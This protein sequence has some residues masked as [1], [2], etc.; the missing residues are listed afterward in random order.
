[1]H[2]LLIYSFVASS[3]LTY[4]FTSSFLST[5]NVVKDINGLKVLPVNEIDVSTMSD[6]LH[7]SSMLLADATDAVV[8]TAQT[9]G[10]WWNSWLDLFKNSLS[11]VHSA[12]DEP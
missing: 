10:G 2:S 3:P 12:I 9:N 8:D 6:F 11:L 4:G 7:Q 5:K 1:M